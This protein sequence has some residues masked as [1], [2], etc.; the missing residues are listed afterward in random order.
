MVKL[1]RRRF[2]REFKL[3]AL[4]ELDGGKSVAQLCREHDLTRFLVSKRKR[5]YDEN[6][7]RA[8][9]S[10]GKACNVA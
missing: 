1:V 3:Q 9:A 4:R 5:E 2:S 8:F 6:P 7:D 10:N